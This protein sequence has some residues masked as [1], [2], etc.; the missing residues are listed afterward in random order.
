MKDYIRS[1]DF[2]GY[3]PSLYIYGETRYK[4]IFTGCLSILVIILS[5][6]CAGY[7]GSELFVRST[8]IVVV[9][10]DIRE[11]FGP[12]NLSNTG[13]LLAISI[14]T[15]DYNY[16]VDPTIYQ[17]SAVNYATGANVSDDKAARNVTIDICSKFYKQEDII[18]NNLQ[19]PLDLHWCVKP[20]DAIIEGFWGSISP[21]NSLRVSV[22]KCVNSTQSNITCKSPA[23]IDAAIQDGYISIEVTKFQVDQK[24]YTNPLKR[25]FNNDYYILNANSSV[26]YTIFLAPFT[27]TSDNGFVFEDKIFYEGFDSRMTV[28]NKFRRSDVIASLL[29]EGYSQSNVIIRSYSKF[30]EILTQVGGFIKMLTTIGNIF[31]LIFSK[32]FYFVDYLFKNELTSIKDNV[33]KPENSDLQKIKQSEL[34]SVNNKFNNYFSEAT[35]N[36]KVEI[37]LTLNLTLV[38][39]L[40]P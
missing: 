21:Y 27:L 34:L 8:P 24:N 3:S 23:E 4:S 13:I 28:F 16:Y 32:S 35:R 9:T 29:L 20:N 6:L 15:P 19:I 2:L 36:Y 38:L 5:L 7:F 30:Q 39:D 10:Q 1:C 22:T 25:I 18:E 26:E 17:V 33:P 37:Y 12:Y 11:S 40:I 14:E 31:S